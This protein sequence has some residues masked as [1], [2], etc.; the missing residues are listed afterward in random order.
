M[1]SRLCKRCHKNCITGVAVEDD[2]I[3]SVGKD[4]TVLL[5]QKTESELICINKFNL[6][7]HINLTSVDILNNQIITSDSI[8]YLHLIPINTNNTNVNTLNGSIFNGNIVNG[9]GIKNKIHN[10]MV[11]Y[12]KYI[13]DNQVISCGYDNKVRVWDLRSLKMPI[14]NLI[15]HTSNV[16][17]LDTIL[18]DKPDEQ[19]ISFTNESF[20]ILSA[21]SDRTT[22]TGTHMVYK[23]PIER[24]QNAECCCII[25][26]KPN[27]IFAVGLDD[28]ILLIYNSKLKNPITQEIIGDNINCIRHYNEIIFVSTSSGELILFNYKFNNKFTECELILLNKLTFPGS[29]NDFKIQYSNNI[30]ICAVGTEL[31]LGR[32]KTNL[33]TNNKNQ[34]IIQYLNI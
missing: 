26:E 29:I 23:I 8:G 28:G 34:I 15:G 5:H 17:Y 19:I 25:L 24:S 9:N 31:R 10:G 7:E 14:H 20:K 32:W 12:V 27:Y 2:K 3:C 16:N 30:L 18:L 11:S 13:N 1:E 21:A 6:S 33:S 4:S 22:N